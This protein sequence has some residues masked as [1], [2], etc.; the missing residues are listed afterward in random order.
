[1]VKF[2][3]V[4]PREDLVAQELKILE[5]WE[6]NQIFQKSL[7]I[8][9]KADRFVFFE[10]PPTANAKPGIHHI[11]G[12]SFKD[13]WPRFK[14]MQGFLVERKAGWD[15]HGLPVEIAL[16]KKLGLSN[17]TDIEKFGI[18]K[19]NA[20][21]KQSVWE[22]KEIWEQS[23]RRM[24][25]WLDLD[26]PYVTY[27]SKYVESLWWV[28]KQ[29]WEKDLLYRGYRVVHHCPRCGTALSSHE[30]AQG[31]QVVE[32]KSVYIKFKLKDEP[33]T[34]ILAWTTT[35]WTLPG[36]VALAVSPDITYAKVDFNGEKLILAKSLIETVL[37]DGTKILEEFSGKE[38][39]D[40]EYEPLFPGAIDAG[41]K[42]SWYVVPAE[43]VTTSEGTGV[44]H[45]AVM[46]GEDDYQLG[47]KLDLPKV[48]TVD[49]SGN[50]VPSVTKWAGK[51]VKDPEVEAGIIQDLQGRGLLLKEELYSHDYP[52]C[53]RCGTPL[54]YYAKDSWF[55]AM[56]KLRDEL[57]ASNEKINWI[58]AHVKAGRFG[59]WLRE[60]KDWA[61]SRERYWGTPLPIWQSE[62]GEQICIGSFAELK[63]LAKDKTKVGED[64]DPHRPHVDEIILE[65]DGKEYT[66]VPEVVDVWFDSG[67]MPFA[68]WHYP[69]E[70]K[71]RI[72]KGESFP[73]DFIS[74]AQDQT[75][76]WF[77]TLL[78]VSV[79]LGKDNP[80][81]NV[82]MQGML[83]DKHGKKM[84]K[85]KGNVVDPQEMFDKYGADVVR[86]YF[87]SVNQPYDSKQFDENV[88]TQIIRRFV[89]TL[90]NTYSFFVTYAKLDNF[91][92]DNLVDKS[93]NVLDKWIL[94][95]L[96]QV[97][98]IVTSSLEKYDPLKAAF[99]LETFVN[100][101]SNWYVRRS[102]KRFWKS[103]DSVDKL[104]AYST[105]YRVIKTLDLVLAPFMPFI[106]EAIYQN[107][108]NDKDPES[109]HLCDWPKVQVADEKILSDMKRTREIVE[110]GHHLR[111]EAKIKVRQPLS[112]LKLTQTKLPTALTDI[113]LDELNVKKLSFG[114]N[115]DELDTDITPDL[116]K[117]GV[118]REIVR[119]VQ[120][121]RKNTGLDVADRIVLTY[122]SDDNLIKATFAEWADY[123]KG[124]VLAV[125]ISAGVK[126]KIDKIIINGYPICLNLV[127]Q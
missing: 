96:D 24:G 118:A 20:E 103:E 8:R 6:K 110:L 27:D 36:N 83:L 25:F 105:L 59:E 89:L 15:T 21:A 31:Y 81:K 61:F 50:F 115:K 107:I 100:D 117:E 78:A 125:E 75:R 123:I 41:D 101:L 38:L 10:G 49:E 54:L 35:P 73:A 32:E 104:A 102:R 52:F 121:L 66:R 80:Y 68:Q 122:E 109:V 58:P 1:M 14:T 2:N 93:D 99:E 106:S 29:I 126:D 62:D 42:K 72:D 7:D 127:K 26:N 19:F 63:D 98:G 71:E 87:Y 114:A 33:D 44:V 112:E 88:M 53:W 91:G 108:K 65:K 40:K 113:A 51:F 18:A 30:V 9:A 120:A 3:D 23:T 45:T 90:W 84:S 64:F 76:G 70:N 28:I 86:W 69:F 82:L 74:E 77:Y 12:R 5:F 94:A 17:K 95:K 4:N 119:A 48:H 79:L 34:Y 43:F 85:S 11:E 60:V 57:M 55:V 67:A 116:E 97:V 47:E 56:S 16:E 37:G 22:F 46:Y 111:E 13:L 39:L 124:E 92:S